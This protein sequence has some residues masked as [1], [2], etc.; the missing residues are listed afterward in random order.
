MVYGHLKKNCQYKMSKIEKII[1]GTNNS[2][3]YK[4]ISDLLPTTVIKHSAKEFNILT[5]E[6]T[7]KS[8]KENSIIKA[9]YFAKK[10]NLICLS[11]DSGLEINILK[12]EPGIYSSRWSGP[13]NDFNLAIEKLYKKINNIKDAW[14]NDIRANFVCCLTLFWPSGKSYSSTGIIKGKISKTKKGNNGFGYDPIF[15]PEGYNKT[16]GE[17]GSKLKMSLDHRLKAYLKIKKFFI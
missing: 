4:E 2:G 13:K 10:T 8:F 11:D 5:P 16:F 17:M 15:I 14:K 3:K 9:S 1:I 7:G 12:G 6:E